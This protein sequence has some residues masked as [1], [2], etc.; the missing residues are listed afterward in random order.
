M[1]RGQRFGF[2]ALALAIIVTAG[3]MLK[4]KPN[5]APT[6]APTPAKQTSA[7]TSG[8]AQPGKPADSTATQAEAEKS[9]PVLVQDKH[10]NIKV[11]KGEE[12]H[13]RVYSKVPEV[14]HIHGYDI[15]RKIP[16]NRAVDVRFKAT[17]DGVYEIEFHGSDTEIAK[18]HVQP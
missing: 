7:R 18:L 10:Q 2:I 4:P 15:E 3:V 9:V 6:T 8:E 5:K 12:V 1:S 11:K 14:I 16:A 17:T 13:F